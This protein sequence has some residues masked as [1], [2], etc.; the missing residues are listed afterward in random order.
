MP[1]SKW[2]VDFLNRAPIQWY[3]KQKSSVE[4]ST[5]G[6]E[7]CAMKVAVEMTEALRYKLTKFQI[8]LD[9]TNGLCPA[10]VYYDDE[11]VHKNTIILKS[12]FRKNYHSIV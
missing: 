11:V 6:A 1:K 5:F 10:N 9:Q 4:T 8:P 12:I 3:I 2:S 7:F